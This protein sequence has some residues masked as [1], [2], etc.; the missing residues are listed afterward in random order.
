[1]NIANSISLPIKNSKVL[2]I[3]S[4]WKIQ[5]RGIFPTGWSSCAG[6][7]VRSP[8]LRFSSMFQE[9]ILS[10]QFPVSSG[11]SHRELEWLPVESEPPKKKTVNESSR[12]VENGTQIYSSENEDF[13]NSSGANTREGSDAVFLSDFR[14]RRPG[15]PQTRSSLPLNTRL[16]NL[17]RKLWRFK[18]S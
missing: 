8:K 16:A 18:T 17:H 11:C 10:A 4:D 2:Y 6:S 15:T 13:R 9:K 5:F 14:E 12:W 7:N 3:S 1:M